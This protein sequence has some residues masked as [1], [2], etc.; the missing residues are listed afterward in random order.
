MEYGPERLAGRDL[1]SELGRPGQFPYARGLKGSGYRVNYWTM[2]QFA[3]HKSAKDTNERFKYLLSHGETG[4]STAFDL[5]TLM[6]LDSD[7][8]RSAGEVGRE[9]VA[10]DSLADMEALFSG[11]DLA[12]V[13]TSMT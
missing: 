9:G 1:L 12:K 6:G 11:I 4:L 8:P 5:P 3:G 2:R 7:D 10:V 13:S